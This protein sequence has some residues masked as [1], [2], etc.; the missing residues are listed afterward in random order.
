MDRKAEEEKKKIEETEN[1]N[2]YEFYLR[3]LWPI[4]NSEFQNFN[5]VYYD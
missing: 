1:K 2:M 5:S 4:S 3:N